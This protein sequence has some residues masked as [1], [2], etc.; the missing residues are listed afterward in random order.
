MRTIWEWLLDEKIV[1]SMLAG[2]FSLMVLVCVHWHAEKEITAGFATLAAM[3]VGSL[4]RGITHQPQQT[5]STQTVASTTT[6]T[7]KEEPKP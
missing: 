7:P 3:C 5:D 6:V 4:T 1:L 2:F